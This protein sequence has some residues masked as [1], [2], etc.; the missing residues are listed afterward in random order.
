MIALGRVSA[1][2]PTSPPR[3]GKLETAHAPFFF[4]P[5]CNA[6][7]RVWQ[8][9]VVLRK[10]K[11]PRAQ[12]ELKKVWLYNAKPRQFG[13][14]SPSRLAIKSKSTTAYFLEST[15]ISRLNGNAVVPST[16]L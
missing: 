10:Q 3:T 9:G 6:R 1:F 5:P 2:Y 7:M 8:S 12:R 13:K 14:I 4:A 11:S 15:K 16:G